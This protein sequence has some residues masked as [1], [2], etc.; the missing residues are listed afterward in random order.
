[1]FRLISTSAGLEAWLSTTNYALYLLAYLHAISPSRPFVAHNLSRMLFLRKTFSSQK[2]T[3]VAGALP[4]FTSPLATLAELISNTRTTLRLFALPSLYIWLR[5]LLDKDKTKKADNVLHYIA[6][7]Q[8]ISYMVY[9]LMESIAY[10]AD[11]GVISKAWL[12]RRGGSAKWWLWSCRA[13]LF[14]V[15]CDFLKLGRQM[16]LQRANKSQNEE[17]KQEEIQMMKEDLVVA[18]CWFP[19]CVHYSLEHGFG[20]INGGIIGAFGLVA[21]LGSFSKMWAQTK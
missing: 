12:Q 14:G 11:C 1:M 13:W 7:A 5:E 9:Q 19:L 15:S 18:G 17:E 4:P 16:Q 21:G 10:L 8:C 20:A 2:L 3:P 6:M